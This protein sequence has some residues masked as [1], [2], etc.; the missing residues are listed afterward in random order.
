MAL[1]KRWALQTG[2]AANSNPEKTKLFTGVS[3]GRAIA[4]NLEAKPLFT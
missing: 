3:A 2:S 1:R 4:I